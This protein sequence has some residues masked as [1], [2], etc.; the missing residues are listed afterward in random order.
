MTTTWL[1]IP[2]QLS[3]DPFHRQEEVGAFSMLL[4]CPAL[5]GV[6]LP[7]AFP[8]LPCLQRGPEVSALDIDTYTEP[9]EFCH[10]VGPEGW[11]AE[12]SQAVGSQAMLSVD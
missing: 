1:L 12:C 4:I 5:Q 10:N 8:R 9:R 6:K 2:E 7:S 11:A 3:L